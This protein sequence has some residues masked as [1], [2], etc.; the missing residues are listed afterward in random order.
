MVNLKASG[1]RISLWVVGG[2][3]LFTG[4]LAGFLGVGGGFIR[5]PALIYLVGCPTT[6]AVGTDLFEVMISGAYGAFT[7]ALKGKVEILAAVLMLMGAAVGAQFGTLATRYVKGLVIRLY[8]AITMLLAGVSVVF[9]H[10]SSEYRYF[11]EEALRPF[12]SGQLGRELSGGDLAALRDWAVT[13]KAEFGTWLAR[14]SPE[15]RSAHRLEAVWNDCA[16]WL[17]LGCACALSLLIVAKMIQGVVRE[18]RLGRAA[19]GLPEGA[20]G[21]EPR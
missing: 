11:Y 15:I 14:Q 13:H 7:Y 16:G 17:M 18:R 19:V 4:F 6:V 9:K 3:A 1:V 2:V 21:K 10:I 8:F 12:V 5:M 20:P